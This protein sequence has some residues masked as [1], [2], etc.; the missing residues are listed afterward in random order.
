VI[1]LAVDDEDGDLVGGDGGRGEHR[2]NRER[3]QRKKTAPYSRHG[4]AL[5]F[6]ESVIA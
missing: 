4:K 1:V 5:S 6:S 3:A 2:R